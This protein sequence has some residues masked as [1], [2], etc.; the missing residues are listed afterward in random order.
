MRRW[1]LP[2]AWG[3]AA[4]VLMNLALFPFRTPQPPDAGFGYLLFGVV[5][6][7]LAVGGAVGC[8]VLLGRRRA[9][10]R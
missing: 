4:Y 10:L 8:A 6:T 1:V 5:Y 2:L 7:I 9:D 3:Y